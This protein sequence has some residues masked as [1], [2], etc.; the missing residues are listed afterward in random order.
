MR[1][2]LLAP[3]A[4]VQ[5]GLL[6][7]AKVIGPAGGGL[8]IGPATGGLAIGAEDIFAVEVSGLGA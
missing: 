6:G 1:V 7:Q 3:W 8:V 5:A 4:W 2:S